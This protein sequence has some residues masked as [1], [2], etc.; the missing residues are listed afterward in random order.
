MRSENH[1]LLGAG[2]RLRC[3][4]CAGAIMI[5]HSV[6]ISPEQ[7][8]AYRKM[9][10]RIFAKKAEQSRQRAEWPFLSPAIHPKPEEPVAS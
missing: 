2:I 1:R 3:R 6:W 7:V 5:H 9:G 10:W 4:D 8:S